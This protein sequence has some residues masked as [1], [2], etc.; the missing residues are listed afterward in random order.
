[1][2]KA[3]GML[4]TANALAGRM[5][6][7]VVASWR[8]PRLAYT[9]RL[10]EL[11]QHFGITSV[12]DVGANAGQFR[13][14]MRD[15]VGFAGPIH[16]FEPDPALAAALARRAASDPAWTVS[17]CALGA[18][19]G[20]MAFNIMDNPVYNSFHAPEGQEAGHAANGNRVVRTVDVE[21]RT[22]DAAAASLPDLAHAFLKIDTQ[23][24]DLEVLKGGEAVARQIPVLQTE[25]S[26][27]R[28][29]SGGPSMDEAIAAFGR[30]GFAVADL[31]L[32]S[33]DG[34][35]RAVE[36]DCIMVQELPASAPPS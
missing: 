10:Q 30:L 22:L 6:F 31:F 16:S 23:G 33:T 36:F 27:R 7:E 5:G 35:H 1:L 32:V 13:D 8:L 34:G 20:T 21:V 17:P 24:F 2:T 12:I 25:V 28:L 3:G 19:A 9:R 4:H 26:L 11:F 14:Q 15:E 29:Y 18:S